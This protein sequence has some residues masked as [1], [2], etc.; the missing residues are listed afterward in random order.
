MFLCRACHES[1]E[2]HDFDKHCFFVSDI[3]E[4]YRH[5]Y[6]KI[7]GDLPLGIS[8]GPCE[9][10]NIDAQCVN[11]RGGDMFMDEEIRSGFK[12]AVIKILGGSEHG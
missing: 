11:C 3:P 2:K 8:V 9:N 7:A 4:D 1:F 12:N 10:C 6:S 5:R